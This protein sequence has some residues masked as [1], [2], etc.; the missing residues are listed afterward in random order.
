MLQKIKLGTKFFLFI[1]FIHV[2]ATAADCDMAASTS[3]TI[4]FGKTTLGLNYSPLHLIRHL[5][6]WT[7]LRTSKVHF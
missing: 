6:V 1:I 3:V 4:S 5:S 7:L 2:V